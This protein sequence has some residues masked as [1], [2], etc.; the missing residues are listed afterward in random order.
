MTNKNGL[1][2][3]ESQAD[4]CQHVNYNRYRFS[5][6][7]PPRIGRQ[8]RPG[9]DELSN[10]VV[11]A[12]LTTPSGRKDKQYLGQ[13]ALGEP[14]KATGTSMFRN[15]HTTLSTVDKCFPKPGQRTATDARHDGMASTNM[16]Q[17]RRK[18][19]YKADRQKHGTTR[20]SDRIWDWR[21]FSTGPMGWVSHGSAFAAHMR[22]ATIAT[23]SHVRILTDVPL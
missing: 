22:M 14:P 3:I 4:V 11:T 7:S 20:R 16:F 6:G 19:G 1:V 5:R 10:P 23:F 2:Q 13:H 9:F 17:Q 12:L 18:H 15:P 8:G 21:Y